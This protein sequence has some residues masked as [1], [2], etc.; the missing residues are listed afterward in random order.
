MMACVRMLGAAA[1]LAG[2]SPALA[3]TADRAPTA[4][5]IT[6]YLWLAGFGADI[7]PFPGGP[8]FRVSKSFG[9]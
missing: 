2:F 5:Q 4:V 1:L 9:E 3:E 8:D 6:P 7:R